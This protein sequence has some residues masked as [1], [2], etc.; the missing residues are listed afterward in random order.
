MDFRYVTVERRTRLRL[1]EVDKRIHICEGRMIVFLHI[2]AVIRVIRESDEPKASLMQAFALSQAQA[3]D[4]LEIR[5]RQLA[6]LEGIKIEKE[7]AE[8]QS[9]RK[10]LQSLLDSRSALTRAIIKEIEA[11]AKSTVTHAAR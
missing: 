7:L 1:D 2:E 8:L 10:A 4:I 9:E 11:D 3:E 6:R 5:L